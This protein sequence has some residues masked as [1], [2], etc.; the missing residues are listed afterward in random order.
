L[1]FFGEALDGIHLVLRDAPVNVAG[2]ADIKRAC[3]AG[4]DIDPECVIESVAHGRKRI[5]AISVELP[6][7]AWLQK[8]PSGS[9]DCAPIS[10]GKGGRVD[11]LRSG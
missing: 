11:A 2:D 5:T 7:A 3:P 9:F 6:D 4:Q 1:Y 8:A 10:D